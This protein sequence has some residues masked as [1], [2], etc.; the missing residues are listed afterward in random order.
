MLFLTIETL[1]AN[2]LREIE[3][4]VF[5]RVLLLPPYCSFLRS[6]SSEHFLTRVDRVEICRSYVKSS[7]YERYYAGRNN[8][9]SSIGTLLEELFSTTSTS[10]YSASLIFLYT[11]QF[12][13]SS[14]LLF[15]VVKVKWDKSISSCCDDYKHYYLTTSCNT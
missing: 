7:P 1:E 6:P 13:M 8:A 9:L 2:I 11:C 5:W 14:K 3:H 10:V 4:A 15:S 12:A